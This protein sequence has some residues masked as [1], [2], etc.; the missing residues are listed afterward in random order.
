MQKFAR[1]PLLRLL[2]PFV[3]GV[4]LYLNIPQNLLFNDF[5]NNVLLLICL[6]ILLSA[7]LFLQL[8]LNIKW[9]ITLLIDIGLLLFGYE[10]SYYQE[11]SHQP[12]FLGNKVKSNEKQYL[13]VKPQ[14]IVVHKGDYN[15]LVFK[16]YKVLNQRNEKWENVLGKVMVYSPKQIAIDTI[17]HPNVYYVLQVRL[18]EVLAV[19]NPY[20]FDYSKYLKRQGIYY[21][22]FINNMSQIQ[23][24]GVQ[25]RWGVSEWALFVRY[26]VVKYFKHNALLSKTSQSIIIA[27]LTGFDDEIENT[28]V[29]SFIYSG[30]LHILSV[31]G[32]HTGLLFLMLS[33]IFSFLDPYQKRK[34]LRTILTVCTLFFYA[35]ISGFSAPVVRAAIMLSLFIIHQYF[36]TDRYIHPF[37]ILSA[38]AFIILVFNPLF[39]DDV[40]F[41]LS[42]SAMIGLVY[43][44][45]HYYFEN[46]ILQNIWS[47]ISMSIGAQVGTLPV[48]LY[49]FHGFAFLF[50]LANIVIIPLSTLIIFFSL[51]AFIPL[52]LISV[53]LNYL[54]HWLIYLNDF[55]CNW[56]MYY[57]WIHFN[58]TDSIFLLILIVGVYVV[59]KKILNKEIHWIVGT[60]FVIFILSIWML[61]H[62]IIWVNSYKNNSFTL[63][64]EKNTTTYWIQNKNRLTFNR[65]D[66]LSMS[67]WIKN[68][69]LK[70]CIRAYR[71]HSFNYVNLSGNKILICTHLSDTLLIKYIKPKILIWNSKILPHSKWV[72]LPELKKIYWVH[73][74]QMIP[75]N[76]SY[77]VISV[78]N[79]QLTELSL[80]NLD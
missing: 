8:F 12:D 78:Y 5:E 30:T 62:H 22:A 9:I 75:N 71:V 1:F 34:W 36:Y 13:I 3:G 26:S 17:F 16:V 74:N 66:S 42:F 4:L 27:L 37:N 39:I 40:G 11:I 79:K 69:L 29:Q 57:N 76:L 32:F 77:K 41:L 21:T 44:S 46:R 45:P 43:F 7:L 67:N 53:L 6:I 48:A 47:I 35:F 64:S 73:S 68:L 24:V 49:F 63:Y 19:D 59:L 31:S 52:S 58:F 72:H 38:A 65:L 18:K 55:F 56:G 61:V 23:S 33:F 10:L 60:S 25:K 80:Q 70:N 28:I 54:V 51:M 2:I 15:R 50:I 20:A 14:D